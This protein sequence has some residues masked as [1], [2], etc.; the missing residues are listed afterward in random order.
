MIWFPSWIL[1]GTFLFFWL[2][3]FTQCS[4]KKI[5]LWVSGLMLTFC[6]KWKTENFG[7][8]LQA[9]NHI[10]QGL[11]FVYV[12]FRGKDICSSDFSAKKNWIE[13]RSE[14]CISLFG[15]TIKIL[16]V[17]INNHCVKFYII[18]AGRKNIFICIKLVLCKQIFQDFLWSSWFKTYIKTFVYNFLCV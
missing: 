3:P 18:E 6:T 15:V 1:C 14:V 16:K 13:S 10:N 7:K 4:D 11:C 5:F 8:T 9:F 2:W 12:T 17:N